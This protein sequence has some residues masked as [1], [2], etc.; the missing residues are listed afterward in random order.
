MTDYISLSVTQPT[1]MHRVSKVYFAN[2]LEGSRY[3]LADVGSADNNWSVP[4]RAFQIQD[5]I[6]KKLVF[7]VLIERNSLSGNLELAT[8]LQLSWAPVCGIIAME[9]N[10]PIIRTYG[11]LA[12]VA[13]QDG[14]V[15]V[16]FGEKV[17]QEESEAVPCADVDGIRTPPTPPIASPA[18]PRPPPP[19]TPPE[20]SE[21]PGPTPKLSSISPPSSPGH[22]PGPPTPPEPSQGF[23]PS[24]PLQ[25]KSKDEEEK[26][27]EDEP[28]KKKQESV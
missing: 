24:P 18:V 19:P 12:N 4:T 14:V 23:P 9:G 2:C 26:R 6:G 10:R 3:A 16:Q 27:E 1:M 13:D 11:S 25:H 7:T 15:L 22:G 21:P 20:H 28:K 8:P 5:I 17:L